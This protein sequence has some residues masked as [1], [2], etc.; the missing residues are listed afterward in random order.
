MLVSSKLNL[1]TMF[2]L[3]TFRNR[4]IF[5]RAICSQGQWEMKKIQG[6]ILLT[7]CMLIINSI[8]YAVLPLPA[9][10]IDFSSK[11]GKQILIK[12]L[13]QTTLNLLENYLTEHGVTYCA[14]A[15][16]VM[17]LNAL[18]L[19]SPDD[20]QHPPYKYFTQENFFTDSVSHVIKPEDVAKHGMT[21]IQ[22]FQ[23]L[24]VHG[25]HAQLFY[26]NKL[27][28]GETR[29]IFRRAIENQHPIIVN[30]LR[31]GI[32]QIG[33]G[34]FSPLAAYDGE[35]D[36]FLFLDVARYK[37]PPSWIKTADLWNAINTI[38]N[39]SGAYRGFIVVS[40]Q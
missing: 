12:N 31:T 6:W 10:L 40:P 18:H 37:Y 5:N 35:S 11:Q 14:V 34:H 22:L 3:A 13:N 20:L 39:D 38:D 32:K 23:T 16:A 1:N 17:V 9:N 26:A 25:V 24:E 36:R 33:G 29:S 8:A 19:S 7:G 15:S 21:L 28:L 30:L 27:T 2:L 4:S